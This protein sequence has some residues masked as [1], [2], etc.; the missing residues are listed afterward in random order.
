MVAPANCNR[1]KVLSSD[2]AESAAE[3]AR[4]VISSLSKAPIIHNDWINDRVDGGC[5]LCERVRIDRIAESER[6]DNVILIWRPPLL[7]PRGN[8]ERNCP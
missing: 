4:Y 5:Y 3:P 8:S 7:A 2:E 6:I 1:C